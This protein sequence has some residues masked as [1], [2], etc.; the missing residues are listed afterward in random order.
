MPELRECKTVFAKTPESGEH[1]VEKHPSEDIGDSAFFAV[2]PFLRDFEQALTNRESV[3]I[4]ELAN[5]VPEN[6]RES[7]IKSMLTIEIRVFQAN[8]WTYNKEARIRDF[9]AFR[10]FID[11]QILAKCQPEVTTE[12]DKTKTISASVQYLVDQFAW[13]EGGQGW[14][15]KGSDQALGGRETAVKILKDLSQIQ[16]FR[17]EAELTARLDHPGVAAVY[18]QG[19]DHDPAFRKEGRP[20]YSMRLVQGQ[21]LDE[22]IAQFHTQDP[23]ATKKKSAFENNPKFVYLLENLI[24]ACQTVAYS[25][26]VG[27]IHCDLKPKN[28]MCGLFGATIVLDWGSARIYDVPVHK[29]HDSTRPLDMQTDTTGSFTLE[30]ASPEQINQEELLSPASDVYSLG[31]TLFHV[32]TG[33]APFENNRR[34][35]T[36]VKNPRSID[37]RIPSRLAAICMKAMSDDAADRY[38]S[39]GDLAK[40]LQNW[41]RDEEIQAVP[42]NPVDRLF[43]VA[44]H[45]KLATLVTLLTICMATIFFVLYSWLRSET[46]RISTSMDAALALIEKTCQPLAND[47]TKNLK[48]FQLIATDIYEFAENYLAEN[49][50]VESGSKLAGV[51]EIRATVKYFFF[52]NFDE[53]DDSPFPGVVNQSD[54]LIDALADL[55]LAEGLYASAQSPDLGGCQLTMARI[56]YQLCREQPS[57]STNSDDLERLKRD[58]YA[59]LEEAIPNLKA[60]SDAESR[61]RLAEAHHLKGEF[62]SR[63]R[64]DDPWDGSNGRSNVAANLELAKSSYMTSIGLRERLKAIKEI[65]RDIARGYGYLGDVQRDLRDF[66]GAIDSY[67]RSLVLREPDQNDFQLGRGLTN[68]GRIIRDFGTEIPD[69][70]IEQLFGSLDAPVSIQVTE[71]YLLPALQIQRMLVQDVRDQRYLNDL[72]GTLNLLAELYLFTAIQHPENRD[73]HLERAADM[74][75]EALKLLSDAPHQLTRNQKLTMATSYM[76]SMQIKRAQGTP[77]ADIREGQLVRDMLLG[78]DFDE[79]TAEPVFAYFVVLANDGP[80]FVKLSEMADLLDKKGFIASWRMKTHLQMALSSAAEGQALPVEEVDEWLQNNVNN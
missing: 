39:P 36:H 18:A 57:T 72:V 58:T 45:H 17:K 64:Y 5:E 20:F 67:Q 32:L 62:V 9:P 38:E 42:D 53:I 37:R 15:H 1:L 16:Q 24:S 63:F 50:S 26:S 40:D 44:R 65:N 80:P 29:Q 34:A 27:V 75:A 22:K 70:T 4:G 8:G 77:H 25:H 21:S 74:I 30:Y 46:N 69:Q 73:A 6:L 59:K 76:L 56:L 71:K 28:I 54:L 13:R 11:E 48:E 51:Y 3:H 41:L 19:V 31:A 66:A 35:G 12:S 60:Q 2:E 14:L 52:N 55:Q 23:V 61:R 43:R 68:F 33:T 7:V 79:L 78:D 49:E 10:S 47:E